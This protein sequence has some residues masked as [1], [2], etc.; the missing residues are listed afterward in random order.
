MDVFISIQMLELTEN[1]VKI[2]YRSF[3]TISFGLRFGVI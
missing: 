1:E 3:Y 2:F